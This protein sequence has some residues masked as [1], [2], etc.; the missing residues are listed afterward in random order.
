VFRGIV[1]TDLRLLE[2]IYLIQ[3]FRYCAMFS[4]HFISLMIFYISGVQN[5]LT[6]HPIS[7]NISNIRH[8]FILSDNMSSIYHN[9]KTKIKTYSSNVLVIVNLPVISSLYVTT[10]SWTKSNRD[11]LSNI[12]FSRDGATKR[13]PLSYRQSSTIVICPA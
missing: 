13:S 5:L 2:N 4:K 6:L 8:I 3:D 10:Q 9:P 12:S 11:S 7:I 1:E